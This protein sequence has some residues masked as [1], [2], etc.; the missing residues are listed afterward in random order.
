MVACGGCQDR[1]NALE[2]EAYARQDAVREALTREVTP[3][4]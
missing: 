3:A 2:A 4:P 1:Q